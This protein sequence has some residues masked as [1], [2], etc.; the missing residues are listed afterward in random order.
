MVIAFAVYISYDTGTSKGNI[1]LI[2][3]AFI[4]CQCD[5]IVIG[6]AFCFDVVDNKLFVTSYLFGPVIKILFQCHNELIVTHAAV[7]LGYGNILKIF[8]A[9]SILE[10][11]FYREFASSYTY[12]C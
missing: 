10:N 1:L 11:Y 4:V 6:S 5:S 3:V 2:F 12:G 9:F 7:C 8:T